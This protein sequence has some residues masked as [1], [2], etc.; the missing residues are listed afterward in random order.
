M[1]GEYHLGRSESKKSTTDE[2]FSQGVRFEASTQRLMYGVWPWPFVP[3]A[4]VL[5]R[6]TRAEGKFGVG[7]L[8][9]GECPV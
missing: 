5:A 4:R 8:G 3:A 7:I 9:D 6:V 2:F 1:E